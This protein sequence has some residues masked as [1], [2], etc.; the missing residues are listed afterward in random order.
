[1]AY[2]DLTAKQ[3]CNYSIQGMP[4]LRARPYP[5]KVAIALQAEAEIDASSRW[6]NAI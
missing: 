3:N 2:F 1:M 6:K 5:I 4:F